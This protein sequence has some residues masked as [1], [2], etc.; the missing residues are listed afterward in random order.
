M[1]SVVA[2]EWGH[3]IAS[4]YGA[5]T[6]LTQR[7]GWDVAH[8]VYEGT[9][10]FRQNLLGNIM[11]IP[12]DLRL[13]KNSDYSEWHR[14]VVLIIDYLVANRQM[15]RVRAE[16]MILD[17]QQH[18]YELLASELGGWDAFRDLFT[19]KLNEAKQVS[20]DKNCI[21]SGPFV[22]RVYADGGAGGGS[23]SLVSCGLLVT[24][25][26]VVRAI[27]Q[28]HTDEVKEWAR[29]LF[30]GA[31]G[32]TE[33]GKGN[34]FFIGGAGAGAG[35]ALMATNLFPPDECG[36]TMVDKLRK[37]VFE[38]LG[39]KDTQTCKKL[40]NVSGRLPIPEGSEGVLS[41]RY[42]CGTNSDGTSSIYQIPSSGTEARIG[43]C[44]PGFGCAASGTRCE[45]TVDNSRIDTFLKELTA[46]V[47]RGALRADDVRLRRLYDLARTRG[48]FVYPGHSFQDWQIDRIDAVCASLPDYYCRGQ[49]LQI[50]VPP[51]S[52]GAYCDGEYIP[53]NA[54]AVH[55]GDYSSNNCSEEKAGYF[56][57]QLIHEL[58][59]N[60]TTD[61]LG[62]SKYGKIC[63]P[64]DATSP[65]CN[66]YPASQTSLLHLWMTMRHLRVGFGI[67]LWGNGVRQDLMR[68]R[69]RILITMSI[70]GQWIIID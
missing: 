23:G 42:R 16:R 56:D 62:S 50:S 55:G 26:R 11:E 46:E 33:D 21:V 13:T 44:N 34:P 4:I 63:P 37:Y 47:Q 69:V 3:L 25:A 14:A 5:D 31:G 70:V 18:G 29:S 59:H 61:L 24:P 30:G 48:I 65:Y 40:E 51:L 67:K 52:G 15:T 36:F 43:T 49:V 10:Q 2:H 19:R 54:G 27:I 35:L 60:V 66:R 20:I 8:K 41:M 38:F 22:P 9:V 39:L 32:G 58:T 68:L 45:A 64:G 53:R 57:G 1:L 28:G 17:A 6:E 12:E 7:Y